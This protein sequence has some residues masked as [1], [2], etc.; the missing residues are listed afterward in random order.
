MAPA[1]PEES[2]AKLVFLMMYRK[3]KQIVPTS[4][5]VSFLW[6]SV[7]KLWDMIIRQ[8]VCKGRT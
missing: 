2:I 6:I 8:C 1:A 4:L 3:S 5:H 7:I